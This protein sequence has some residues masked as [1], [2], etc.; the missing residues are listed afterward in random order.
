MERLGGGLQ[1]L[2]AE[3]KQQ[4]AEVTS[5]Y[6]ARIAQARLEAEGRLQGA[7]DAEAEAK[8][9][10]D[11]AREVARFEE[12]REAKKAELRKGFGV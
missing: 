12:Q 10:A 8:I 7:K 2:S 3:Q 9:R 5:L 11:L 4:L 6:E 1:A